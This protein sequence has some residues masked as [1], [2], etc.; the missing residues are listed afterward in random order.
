MTG[1][2]Q[3]TPFQA[4]FEFREGQKKAL[5]LL[6]STAIT[7][8]LIYG[9]GR[10]GK[11]VAILIWI[12]MRCLKYAGSRHAVF[13]STRIS[14]Q[15]AVFGDTLQKVINLLNPLLAKQLTI[16]KSDL[17]V[18]FPNGSMIDFGGLDDHNRDNVLGMEWQTIW[19]NECNGFS[20]EDV[21]FLASRLNGTAK[22]DKGETI[23][24]KMVF[25]CN[26]ESKNDW[27]YKV[28][29]QGVSPGTN[30]PLANK[31][32]YGSIQ[33]NNDDPEY[34]ANYAN[35][36]QKTINRLVLGVWT[37]DNPNAMFKQKW[38]ND[39]RVAWE[40]FDKGKMRTIT[41]NLDP[42]TT[43]NKK[44][45]EC[46]LTVTAIDHKGH[47]YVLAD[48]SRKMPPAE[49]AKEALK[50][51]DE[52][53]ADYIVAE[54]NQGGLMVT[55]TI[56]RQD[57]HAPVRLVHASRGKAARADPIAILYERGLVHHVGDLDELED[58]MISFDSPTFRGSPDRLDSV[59]WGLSELFKTANTKGA[60]T[61]TVSYTPMF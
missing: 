15:K 41:V 53:D 24:R 56:Y 58:Q 52:F 38:I 11:S 61:I 37:D 55:E 17:Q 27:E 33:V 47:G 40:E 6:T 43:D 39:N 8:P 1:Q 32:Q 18:I 14:C 5:D 46:G 13:K 28:F 50:L 12:F 31:E 57:P 20:Y 51:L 23:I 59:V 30:K 34:L 49:W 10:S 48:R 9:G 45:D 42:S 7:W 44:S 60:G 36:S 3:L 2:N 25:D 21:E 35:A 4:D 22:D 29:I 19:M 54:K 26:P 16:N